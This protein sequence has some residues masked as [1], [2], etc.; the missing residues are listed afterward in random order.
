M[1]FDIKISQD[2]VR[3]GCPLRYSLYGAHL[4]SFECGPVFACLEYFAPARKILHKR[5]AL[6]CDYVRLLGQSKATLR[7]TKFSSLFKTLLRR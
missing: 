6:R 4:F 7:K 5:S 3:S 2:V 1:V